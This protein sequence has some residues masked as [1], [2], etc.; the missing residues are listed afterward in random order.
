MYGNK[1]YLHIDW[2]P[3]R[4][5]SYLHQ[6]SAFKAAPIWKRAYDDTILLGTSTYDQK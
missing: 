4:R 5:F 2:W 1:N 3:G 6:L